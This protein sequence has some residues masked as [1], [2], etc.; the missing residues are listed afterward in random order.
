MNTYNKLIRLSLMIMLLLSIGIIGCSDDPTS[1]NT[2]STESFDKV[3]QDGGDFVTETPSN[4][5]LSEEEYIDTSGTEIYFCT[6]KRISITETP[7]MFPLFNPN[8]DIVFPGNL[9]QGATLEN[10]TPSPIPVKRAGGRIVMTIINGSETSYRDIP[11]VDLGNVI[12]A[13]N[14]IIATA[15]NT[16][17][18]NFTFTKEEIHTNEELALSLDIKAQYLST[19]VGGS[20]DFSSDKEYNRYLVKL[21]QSFFTMAYQLPTSYAEIFAPEV[22]PE[23]LAPYI[24]PGNPGAFISSVTY[25]RIF[26]LLI[27]STESSTEMLASIEASFNAAVSKGELEANARYL[28]ELSDVRVK[29]FAMGGE[30]GDAINAI[31]SNF[32]SL[33]TFLARGGTINSGVPVSYVVRSLSNPSKIVSVKINTEYDLTQCISVNESFENPIFW[34]RVDDNTFYTKPTSANKLSKLV[35]AFGDPALDAIP[36]SKTYGC[37]LVPNALAG[38]TMPAMRFRS[39]LSDVD[40]MF[41]YPGLNFVNT[42]Y[43]VIVVAKLESTAISYPEMFLWGSS[44]N[45]NQNLQLGYRD[46][47]KLTLSHQA[48]R[49]DANAGTDFSKFNIFTF[50]FSQEDGMSIYVNGE[51]TAA[52]IDASKTN[53]LTAYLGARFGSR[54]GNALQIA[55]I[56]TYGIAI[57]DSQ[58]NFAVNNL[59]TKYSL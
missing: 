33:K 34:Y 46:D 13:Q 42:D 59:L 16:V 22:T 10:A 14:D 29:A 1:P 55:E 39:G 20:L 44:S 27:E 38:G 49:I 56:K 53:P 15:N 24:G 9:L 30:A 37:E 7:D 35:N 36:V 6:T 4:D 51:Q 47:T 21:N 2:G 50:I 5:T 12:Q 19:K 8:A 26:Y 31:T 41:S 32:D 58:R 54:Y 25:G 48:N 57:N 3:I 23:D 43:T 45:T 11:V 18:A 40:G 52:G 28:S 17:P